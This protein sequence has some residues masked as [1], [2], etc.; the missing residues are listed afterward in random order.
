LHVS[1]VNPTSNIRVKICCIANI[2][3]ARLAV[4]FGASAIGLV[5]AMPSGPGPISEDLIA[6]IA[7]TIPPGVAT[8]LLTS[9]QDAA[10]II[11]QQHRAETNTIQIVDEFPL[12]KYGILRKEL[13]GVKLVQVVHVRDKSSIKK[14]VELSG[15]VDAIL[16]DSGN[17]NLE[18]KELGGTG[19]V[20]D[21]SISKAIREKVSIPVYLAG[22]LTSENVV[23]AIKTVG[24]F[25]VDVCSGVRTNGKLDEKKLNE[26]FRSVSR[27][28]IK[29]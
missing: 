28:K 24:P 16:L 4:S 18:T 14:A 8:F 9:K 23:R 27:S 5:S 17:P 25:A 20:H 22:G 7:A 12:A 11:A 29:T 21:W 6:T 3:E 2:E 19:R 26:F 13:P 10:G 1:D 15:Y